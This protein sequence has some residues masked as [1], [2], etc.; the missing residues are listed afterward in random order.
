MDEKILEGIG[1]TKGEVK[2]YLA[3]LKIGETTTGK[4]IEEAQISAGKIYQ[5]LDKLIKKGLASYIIKDKTK[6]FSATN[7]NR[8]LD[9]LHEEEIK[10]KAKENEISK[11]L[12]SLIQKYKSEKKDHETTLFKGFKGVQTAI[13]ELLDNTNSK[14]VILAMG[15]TTSKNEKFNILWERWHKQ[16]IKRKIKCK[17][18]F[19]NINKEYAGKFKKMKFTQVKFLKGIT[20][21]AISISEDYILIQTYKKEPSCLLIKNEEIVQSF[22]T[23]FKTM[24]DS[25]ISK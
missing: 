11:I 7:P 21:S 22:K 19:S 9:F 18:L 5:I 13:F 25:G 1:L 16:R 17:C 4:I 23:F 12:P 10:F 8:I 24:W 6:Y 3:L 14:E 15:I 2:V 20:P